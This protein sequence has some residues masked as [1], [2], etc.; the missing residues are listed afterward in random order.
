MVGIIN[1]YTCT[2]VIQSLHEHSQQTG[3]WLFWNERRIMI[4]RRPRQVLGW[5]H[6][7]TRRP[8]LC[9]HL[10]ERSTCPILVDESH[11]RYSLRCRHVLKSI[12]IYRTYDICLPFVLLRSIRFVSFCSA[13]IFFFSKICLC[14]RT[15]IEKKKDVKEWLLW[16]KD[17]KKNDL[18]ITLLEE[19]E[20]YRFSL[21]F[22]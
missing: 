6:R 16:C 4:L 21:F 12:I 18:I 10:H 7:T 15:H 17:K 8:F 9:L 2:Y 20:N 3:N 22:D 11:W 5:L 13:F 19:K 14:V 1:I